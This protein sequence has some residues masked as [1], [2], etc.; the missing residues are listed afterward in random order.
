MDIEERFKIHPPPE[1]KNEKIAIIEKQIED[2]AKKFAN[3]PCP[4][5]AALRERMEKAE[6]GSYRVDAAIERFLERWDYQTK[7]KERHDFLVIDV[8]ED[9]VAT[10]RTQRRKR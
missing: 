8:L 7:G 6:T 10:L 5:C 2:I 1:D 4:S 9:V 3:K